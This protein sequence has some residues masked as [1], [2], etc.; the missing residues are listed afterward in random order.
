MKKSILDYVLEVENILKNKKIDNIDDV[1]ENHLI[2]ISFYQ[3]ERLIHLIVTVL[4]AILSIISFLYTINFPSI[5]LMILTFMFLLLLIP[6]IMHYYLLENNVQKL[7]IYYDK[8]KKIK[9]KNI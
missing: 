9:D 3:H 8:M 1:I 7:Y 4:F 6:Y 5:G 2:K